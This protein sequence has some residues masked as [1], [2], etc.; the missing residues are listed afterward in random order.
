MAEAKWNYRKN[1]FSIMSKLNFYGPWGFKA[2]QKW[3]KPLDKKW[4]TD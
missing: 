1:Q 3:G 4:V 2:Q